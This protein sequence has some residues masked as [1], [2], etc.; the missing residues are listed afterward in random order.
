M[1][2]YRAVKL[3]SRVL[4]YMLSSHMPISLAVAS[5]SSWP[6]GSGLLGSLPTYSSC[7][8]STRP[9]WLPSSW[10]TSGSRAGT[11]LVYHSITISVPTISLEKTAVEIQKKQISGFFFSSRFSSPPP[12]SPSPH[13]TR[14]KSNL[15]ERKKKKKKKKKKDLIITLQ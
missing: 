11:L 15:Q 10:M 8:Y 2:I 12:S 7:M 5:S 3:Q 14:I 9:Q 4:G 6:W 13:G 1:H